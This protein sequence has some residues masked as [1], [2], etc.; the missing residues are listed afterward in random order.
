MKEN[1]LD[2]DMT[3][4]RKQCG[5]YKTATLNWDKLRRRSK[6]KMTIYLD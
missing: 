3:L 4:D 2:E 6:S 1:N 5:S